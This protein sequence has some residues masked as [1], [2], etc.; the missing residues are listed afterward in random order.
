MI[1]H[2]FNFIFIENTS[3]NKEKAFHYY[4]KKTNKKHLFSMYRC[5]Q[6]F[7]KGDGILMN[8]YKKKVLHKSIKIQLF[9]INTFFYTN[10]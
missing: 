6:M 10:T 1:S 8:I 4:F 3:S 7:E 5:A 2:D 9:T